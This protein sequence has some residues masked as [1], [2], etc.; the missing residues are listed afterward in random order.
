MAKKR[1]IFRGDK[2]TSAGAYSPGSVVGGMV[3]V[4]G[5]GPLDPET[6]KMALLGTGITGLATGQTRT[7]VL[8]LADNGVGV[9]SGSTLHLGTDGPGFAPNGYGSFGIELDMNPG[10]EIPEPATLLLLGTGALGVLGFI[11][12][13]RIE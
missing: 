10:A 6:G 4:S 12:R 9:L 13:R 2:D 11:R 1:A 5:Q 8:E 7:F 3:F